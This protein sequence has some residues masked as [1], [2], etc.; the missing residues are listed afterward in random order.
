MIIASL[1]LARANLCLQLVRANFR[2]QLACARL[3]LKLACATTLSGIWASSSLA[4][5]VVPAPLPYTPEVGNAK[6][7][8]PKSLG[9][10]NYPNLRL[11]GIISNDAA[12]QTNTGPALQ[13]MSKG[14]ELI[15]PSAETEIQT[16]FGTVLLKRDSLALVVATSKSLSVF[17]FE[18]EHDGVAIDVDGYKVTLHPG[19]H[20]TVTSAQTERFENVNPATFIGYKKMRSETIGGKFKVFE[21]E[22]NI[23]SGINGI[24]PLRQIMANPDHREKRLADHLLKTAAVQTAVADGAGETY[25]ITAGPVI[26]DF[27]RE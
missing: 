2:L 23:I 12:S 7:I 10:E 18:D 27:M 6:A 26:I 13:K 1:Q 21:A 9:I 15:A 20:A 25:Q 4:Q 17:D 5:V 14:A 16:G 3:G 11:L 22:F 24:E 8:S 19:Y